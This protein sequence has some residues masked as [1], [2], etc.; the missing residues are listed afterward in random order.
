MR[1]T[2]QASLD[3]VVSSTM[4]YYAQDFCGLSNALERVEKDAVLR[5]LWPFLWVG[6]A[7]GDLGEGGA[8]GVVGG[9]ASDACALF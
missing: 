5:E 7:P 4:V 9:P 2:P 8:M 6:A 1:H 3:A